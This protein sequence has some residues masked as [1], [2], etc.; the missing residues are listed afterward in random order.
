MDILDILEGGFDAIPTEGWAPLKVRF[1][2]GVAYDL[3]YDNENLTN[4]DGAE[5][6]IIDT[7]SDDGKYLLFDNE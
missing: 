6:I 1:S 3:I 7:E 4:Q 2:A 5:Y